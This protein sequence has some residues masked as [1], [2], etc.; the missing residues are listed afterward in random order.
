MTSPVSLSDTTE[1]SSKAP[2]RRGRGAGGG[3]REARNSAPLPLRHT[4]ALRS[5]S[6]CLLHPSPPTVTG[7]PM[8]TLTLTPACLTVFTTFWCVHGFNLETDNP[9][10][11]TED[12][13]SQFGL[14]VAQFNANSQKWTLVSAPLLQ[15]INRNKTGAIFK[16]L[17]NDRLC[18]KLNTPVASGSENM[19]L[20]LTTGN[21]NGPKFLACVPR[22]SYYCYTNTYINGYCELFNHQGTVTERIPSKLPVCP[23]V[24][25]DIAFLIDGS[26]SVNSVDFQQMKDFIKEIMRKFR[27]AETQMALAQFSHNARTE[28][29]LN[30]YKQ[31]SDKERLVNRISQIRGGTNTQMG[32]TTS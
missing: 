8:G 16:C 19:G 18:T 12:P 23:K 22:Y 15:D 9:V 25:V 32:S 26:G 7:H 31:A 21:S 1:T 6:V 10:T 2:T 24:L 5:V 30:G 17:Y 27:N 20:S 13:Q 29:T 14:R 4:T 3:D 11:F 28:F